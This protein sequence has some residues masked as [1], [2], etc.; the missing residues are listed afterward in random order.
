MKPKLV[1]DTNVYVAAMLGGRGALKLLHLWRLKRFEVY[2][3]KK[4]IE[5][6]YITVEKHL[7]GPKARRIITAEV[8]E[9]MLYLLSARAELLPVR[10]VSKLSRDRDDDWIIAIALKSDYLV[11]ENTQDVNIQALPQSANTKM[12]TIAQAVRLFKESEPSHRN[13]SG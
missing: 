5:E 11:S 2:T 1:L 10:R 6:L 8:P 12:L 3:S 4:Q 7:Q 13:R 9:D